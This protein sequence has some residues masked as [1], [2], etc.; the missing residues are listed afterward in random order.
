M[1]SLYRLYIDESGDHGYSKL[2]DPNERYLGLT[3]TIFKQSDRHGFA[4]KMEELKVDFLAIIYLTQS[5][6]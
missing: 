4:R 5:P 1:G 6:L 3:A 2:D